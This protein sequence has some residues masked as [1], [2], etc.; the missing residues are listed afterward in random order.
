M[1][2]AISRRTHGLRKSRW[3]WSSLIARTGYLQAPVPRQDHP[4]RVTKLRANRLQLDR[5]NRLLLRVRIASVF[6]IEN[7]EEEYRG[8][9]EEIAVP[10]VMVTV[11]DP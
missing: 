6:V 7:D 5:T 3:T 8:R 1:V 10:A 2:E 4:N 11:R 9:F